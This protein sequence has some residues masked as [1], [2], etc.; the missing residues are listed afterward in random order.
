LHDAITSDYSAED[1]LVKLD[2]AKELKQA[3]DD[4]STG[5][6][7]LSKEFAKDHDDL[8]KLSFSTIASQI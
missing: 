5:M 3:V 7:D 6:S 4:A 2:E 8:M 1:I